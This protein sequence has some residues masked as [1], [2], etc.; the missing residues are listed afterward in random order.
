MLHNKM[1][2]C[3]T[4]HLIQESISIVAGF[5]DA[6]IS[7]KWI[8]H[9]STPLRQLNERISSSRI[10]DHYL[11]AEQDRQHLPPFSQDRNYLITIHNYMFPT[12]HDK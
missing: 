6:A 8:F 11:V 5:E 10:D 4:F 3:S 2:K 7:P 12:L 1:W 9:V